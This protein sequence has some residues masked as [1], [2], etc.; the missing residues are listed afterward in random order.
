MVS[1][2]HFGEARTLVCRTRVRI[3]NE[4]ICGVAVLVFAGAGAGV[5]CA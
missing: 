2:V 4:L 3:C 5:L 1:W